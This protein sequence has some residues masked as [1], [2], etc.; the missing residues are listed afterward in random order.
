[1]KKHISSKQIY[2]NKLPNGEIKFVD[3]YVSFLTYLFSQAGFNIKNIKTP[4]AFERA[5]ESADPYFH[6]AIMFEI[7]KS[8]NKY[9]TRAFQNIAEGN[10]EDFEKYCLKGNKFNMLR[11]NMIVNK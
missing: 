11:K 2:Y 6:K 1:M 4:Q 9:Y 8:N 10:I 3:E 5:F 7:N